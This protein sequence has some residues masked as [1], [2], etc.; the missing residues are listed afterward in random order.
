MISLNH[1]A[2]GSC[3]SS[4]SFIAFVL[5]AAAAGDSCCRVL[6]LLLLLLLVAAYMQ[7]IRS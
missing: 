3:R 5:A 7:V 6:L 2:T 1:Y 4:V